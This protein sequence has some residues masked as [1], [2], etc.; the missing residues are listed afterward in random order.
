MAK[1]VRRTR[2]S[3]KDANQD[4]IVAALEA[5]GCSV[6]DASAIG[7]DFP[8]LV[9]GRLGRTYLIEVKNPEARGKL[10]DGQL[11]FFDWWRG[12]VDQAETVDDALRIVGAIE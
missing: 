9:V 4:G 6:V 2:L 11:K 1:R 12:Q 7:C 3:K 10:T 5:V 8:D